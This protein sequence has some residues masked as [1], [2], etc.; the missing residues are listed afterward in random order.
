MEMG[1]NPTFVRTYKNY[2]ITFREIL[3]FKTRGVQ[4]QKSGGFV[5]QD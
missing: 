5:Y 3:L 1:E 4:T 2:M